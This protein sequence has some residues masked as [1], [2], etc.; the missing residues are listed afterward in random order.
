MITNLRCLF[1]ANDNPGP[2]DFS[3]SGNLIWKD[4]KVT[5][6]GRNKCYFDEEGK[7]KS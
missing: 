4:R 1:I 3:T 2:S 7:K 6:K 5:I